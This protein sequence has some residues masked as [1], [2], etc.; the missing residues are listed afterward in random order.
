V[1]RAIDVLDDEGTRNLD[2]FEGWWR[3]LV[4]GKER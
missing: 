4:Q 3:L 1:S 2:E